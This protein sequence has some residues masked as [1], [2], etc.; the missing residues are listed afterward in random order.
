MHVWAWEDNPNGVFSDWNS[1]VTC[2]KQESRN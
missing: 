2:A 1:R